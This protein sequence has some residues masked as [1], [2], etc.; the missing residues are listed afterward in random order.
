MLVPLRD[1]L[2]F[3]CLRRAVVGLLRAV[4]AT[5]GEL[6]FG[7]LRDTEGVCFWR[8]APCEVDLPSSGW[9]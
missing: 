1:E 2:V 5:Q 8:L 9:R 6:A 4:Y 3:C 7:G